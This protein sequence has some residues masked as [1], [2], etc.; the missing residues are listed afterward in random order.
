MGECFLVLFIISLTLDPALQE[1]TNGLKVQRGGKKLKQAFSLIFAMLPVV[2]SFFSLPDTMLVIVLLTCFLTSLLLHL[3]DDQ[4]E[5]PAMA[6]ISN[7]K[8]FSLVTLLAPFVLGFFVAPRPLESSIIQTKG[9]AIASPQSTSGVTFKPLE[10]Q[11]EKMDI[12]DWLQ[13][14]YTLSD[15]LILAGEQINLTGF[16]YR[17]SQLDESRFVLSRF[18][19]SCCAADAY[20]VGI[21][22]EWPGALDLLNDEWV[23][24]QGTISIIGSGEN[25]A[26]EIKAE[27]VDPIS[28]PKQPYLFP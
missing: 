15:P 24:V 14:F 26:L 9:I 17:D 2:L 16:V 7:R 3:F 5:D 8:I 6:G 23:E 22:V 4:G 20:A 12:L 28:Q 13:Y 18:V 25:K 27:S 21:T 10:I 1:E 11:P 19:I